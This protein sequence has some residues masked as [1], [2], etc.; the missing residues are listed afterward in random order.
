MTILARLDLLEAAI[1]AALHANNFQHAFDVAAAVVPALL[2]EVHL[3]HAI[4]LEDKGG[5]HVAL[6]LLSPATTLFP[7]VVS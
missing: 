7:G 4:F 6:P 1:D 2:P 5:L 3:R